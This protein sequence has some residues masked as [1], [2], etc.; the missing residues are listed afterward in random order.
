[1][2]K[3]A[4]SLVEA[5]P[6]LK[7]LV[8]EV[9]ES[10]QL[11][12]AC[13]IYIPIEIFLTELEV[14][15]YFTHHVTFPFL[16][17]V[18]KSTQVQ[19]LSTFPKLYTD[20]KE[21]K[22]NTLKDFVVDTRHVPV[23]YRFAAESSTRATDLSVLT[24]EQLCGLPTGNLKCERN[25][26]IFN[27]RAEKGA[28]N[29]NRKFTAKS[30]RNDV[31]LYRD[32]QDEVDP[33]MKFVTKLLDERASCVDRQSKKKVTSERII[34]KLMKAGNL[35]NMIMKLLKDCKTWNGPV[36]SSNE[37]I[38]LKSTPMPAKIHPTH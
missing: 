25:L 11:V 14:L 34:E 28:K 8:G 18:E 31:M 23:K 36:T 33:A 26:L 21:G 17:L 7:L 6:I 10:N 32:V 12:E 9:V 29:R 19:L 24:K 35:N 13:K 5:Y 30:I 37:L 3:S 4:A 38:N 27:T 22:T 1:M 20:L 16:H 2:C 15:A